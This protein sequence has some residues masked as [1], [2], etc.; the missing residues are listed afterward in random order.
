[1]PEAVFG[2]HVGIAQQ[3]GQFGTRPGPL[4]ASADRYVIRVNGR[5][6]HGAQPWAGVDP[7]VTA[8]QIIMGIQTIASRQLNVTQAPSIISVGRIQGGIRNNVI[9]D[10]V[11]FEGTIRAFD[12]DMRADIHR[13]L[14]HTARSIAE[15][16]GATIEFELELGSPPVRNDVELTQRML[17][18][19]E[20]ASGQPVNI[21]NPQTVAE[22][23]SEYGVFTPSLFVFLGNVPPGTDPAQAPGNHSPL[24]DMYE[25]SLE[26]GVKAFVN[27]VTDY[28]R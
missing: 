9:P 12:P 2:I 3:A 16:A 17:P 27:M 13:R 18:A 28:L 19:L 20:R 23:F 11:E 15:A 10:S 8:A 21:M 5:Q 14:E 4:M 7:I 6:T 26:V 22:D 25:P 1:M 24:F